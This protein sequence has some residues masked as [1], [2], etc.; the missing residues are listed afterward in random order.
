MS[1]V[2]IEDASNSFAR[3]E[4]Q[5]R[6]VERQADDGELCQDR[7]AQLESVLSEDGTRNGAG[8]VEVQMLNRSISCSRDIGA[9]V[10]RQGDQHAIEHL[11]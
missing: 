11:R 7:Q 4:I 10:T 3:D 9:T 8:E 6:H 2:G 1:I 5:I